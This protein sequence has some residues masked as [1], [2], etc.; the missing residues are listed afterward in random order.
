LEY[1]VGQESAVARLRAILKTGQSRA[2]LMHGA[3]GL[4]KSLAAISCAKA[5][6]CDIVNNEFGGYLCVAAGEQTAEAVRRLDGFMAQIPFTGSGWRCIQVDEADQMNGQ[7]EAVW[8][9]LLEK[10]PTRVL[11]IFTTNNLHK[12]SQ[13]FRDRCSVIAFDGKADLYSRSAIE[14]VA[15]REWE[16]MAPGRRMLA[17]A[18]QRIMATAIGG[19]GLVSY[20]RAARAAEEEALLAISE[21]VKPDLSWCKGA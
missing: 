18:M 8:L 2:I 14:A 19:D 6:G 21:P 7:C 11:V 3:T 10:L 12:L 17:D 20:R 13:R 9:G 15:Y 4:G 16:A 1:I 5:T